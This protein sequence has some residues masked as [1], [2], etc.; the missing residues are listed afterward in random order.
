M[1]SE[2]C[3]FCDSECAVP[4]ASQGKGHTDDAVNAEEQFSCFVV[5]HIDLYLRNQLPH[6]K[7]HVSAV[8]DPSFRIFDKDAWAGLEGWEF[9]HEI[10]EEEL[11]E[12]ESAQ[13]R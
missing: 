9:V 4:D 12:G 2:S 13:L 3:I 5:F 7:V 1:T 6:L 11:V 10:K 8:V